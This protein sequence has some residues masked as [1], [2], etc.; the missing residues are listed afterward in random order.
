[1]KRHNIETMNSLPIIHESDEMHPRVQLRS[2]FSAE[3]PGQD[4]KQGGPQHNGSLYDPSFLARSNESI[5]AE[6]IKNPFFKAKLNYLIKDHKT[7]PQQLTPLT[8]TIN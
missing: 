7:T 2:K 8:V 6:Y 3:L 1:M 4:R 5:I